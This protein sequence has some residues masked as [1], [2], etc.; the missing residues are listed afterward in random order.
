MLQILGAIL[1][2]GGLLTAI[3]AAESQGKLD[4]G[5]FARFVFHLAYGAFW[6]GVLLA[7]L[8]GLGF[9]AWFT[10]ETGKQVYQERKEKAR[11][12]ALEATLNAY[13]DEPDPRKA[14]QIRERWM[15]NSGAWI[16]SKQEVDWEHRKPSGKK[17]LQ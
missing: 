3:K 6:S 16:P 14:E 15:S 4:L 10:Y 7:M 8:G 2:V 11:S 17:T 12:A 9:A 1:L 5:R 13:L